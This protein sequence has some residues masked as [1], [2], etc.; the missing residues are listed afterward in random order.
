MDQPL[1]IVVDQVLEGSDQEWDRAAQSAHA[2]S[3]QF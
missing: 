2:M 1:Q 3:V